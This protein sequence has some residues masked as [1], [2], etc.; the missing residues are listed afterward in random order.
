MSFNK[1][2]TK[3]MFHPQNGNHEAILKTCYLKG[4]VCM[5]VSHVYVCIYHVYMPYVCIGHICDPI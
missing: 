4:Y 5:C 2:Q 3:S 1:G